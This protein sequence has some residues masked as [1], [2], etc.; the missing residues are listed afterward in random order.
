[1][2]TPA[3]NVIATFDQ[4]PDGEKREVAATILRRTLQVEFPPLSDDVLVLNAEE[5]FS[6]LDRREAEDARS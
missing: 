5:V 2:G 4:L 3:E 1:M 6:E